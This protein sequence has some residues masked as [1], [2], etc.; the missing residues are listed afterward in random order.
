MMANLDYPDINDI[1]KNK[2]IQLVYQ[3][4]GR[5]N[6]LS[7]DTPLLY[8]GRGQCMRLIKP[9]SHLSASYLDPIQLQSNIKE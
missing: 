5:A 6:S 3:I 9:F 8:S 2:V 7:R 1:H 4:S